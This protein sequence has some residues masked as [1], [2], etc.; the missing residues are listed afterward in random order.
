MSALTNYNKLISDFCVDLSRTFPDYMHLWQQWESTELPEEELKHLLEYM[1]Q[2]FPERFF[3][4]LYQNE[5]VFTKKTA[6]EAN[7]CFLP[8][9]DFRV[10]FLLNISEHTKQTLWKY[11]Q[12]LMFQIME[13]VKNKAAFG[14]TANIFENIKEEDL[15]KK[16]QETFDNLQEF[17]KNASAASSGEDGSSTEKEDKKSFSGIDMEK[18]QEHL[19]KLMNGRIGSLVKEL[20][21]ELKD[22]FETF[23]EELKEQMGDVNEGNGVPDMSTMMKHMMKD[24]TKVMPIMK[25]VSEKLKTHMTAE[26]Q[27]EYMNETMDLLKEM[28]GRDEF[29]KIFEQMKHNMGGQG[30]NMRMD[31]NAL[32]R[33]EKTSAMK[34]R[35]R[36]NLQEKKAA[37]AAAETSDPNLK[38]RPDG[39]SVFKIEGQEQPKTSKEDIERLMK[40]FG[41]AEEPQKPKKKSGGGKKKGSV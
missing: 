36:R 35:I 26:N 20:M 22:D 7:V 28:G 29:M 19:K 39:T 33:L 41:L 24:P 14:E 11:L 10:L 5:D 32:T 30:K 38:T 3:D 18:I 17:F 27:R 21:D 25:K 37:V 9:V 4:I 1:A 40:E 6:E 23:Q 13:E 12:L 16:L 15:Q 31:M 2:V 8:G 34:E